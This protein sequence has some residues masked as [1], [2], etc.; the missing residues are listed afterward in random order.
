MCEGPAAVAAIWLWRLVEPGAYAGF[1]PGTALHNRPGH[2]RVSR[3]CTLSHRRNHTTFC[4]D[5]RKSPYRGNLR[6]DAATVSH[7]RIG[8]I[9]LTVIVTGTEHGRIVALR[10]CPW[11]HTR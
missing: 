1:V 8:Y 10:L 5:E 9:N 11:T 7:F 4:E 2:L 6:H 3:I